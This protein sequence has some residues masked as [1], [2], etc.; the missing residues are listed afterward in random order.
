MDDGHDPKIL[1]TWAE[2][3]SFSVTVMRRIFIEVTLVFPVTDG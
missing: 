3:D 1:L 2:T